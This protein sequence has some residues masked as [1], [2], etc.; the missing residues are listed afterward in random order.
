[1]NKWSDPLLNCPRFLQRVFVRRLQQVEFR[2]CATGAVVI[3]THGRWRQVPPPTAIGYHF[4]SCHGSTAISITLPNY[5]VLPS[6]DVP[7]CSIPCRVLFTTEIPQSSSVIIA[8]MWLGRNTFYRCTQ[9]RHVAA[10][11]AAAF[12]PSPSNFHRLTFPT[13][14]WV[15]AVMESQLKKAV[16]ARWYSLYFEA[17]SVWEVVEEPTDQYLLR[18]VCSMDNVRLYIPRLAAF[19][20]PEGVHAVL[21]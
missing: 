20:L 1:M 9:L 3:P 21:C 5:R 2:Q 14:M 7:R 19:V 16:K 13:A 17:S 10:R 15:K 4:R 11:R 8:N 12:S 18:G 6:I